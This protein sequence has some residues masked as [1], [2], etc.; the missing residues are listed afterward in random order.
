MKFD[1]T[2]EDTGGLTREQV[3][4][5]PETQKA[6]GGT[7]LYDSIVSACTNRMGAA[8]WSKP[9]RRVLVLIS[10]GEDNQSHVRRD[11]GLTDAIQG[12]V[13]IF[14]FDTSVLTGTPRGNSVMEDFTKLTVGEFFPNVGDADTVEAFSDTLR[15]MDGMYLASFPTAASAGRIS[16]IEVKSAAGE[17]LEILSPK[18]HISEQ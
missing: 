9:A 10:E 1:V 16:D 14:A 18:K 5:A 3:P 2:P 15:L 6:G 12:G 11:V 17:K 4:G 8:D 7:A 13:V